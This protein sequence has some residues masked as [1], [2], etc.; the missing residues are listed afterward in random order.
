MIFTLL[1]CVNPWAH[2]RHP[3]W[4]VSSRLPHQIASIARDLS[5]QEAEF[6]MIVESNDGVPAVLTNFRGCRKSTVCKRYA[7]RTPG[8]S[9]ASASTFRDDP[10]KNLTSFH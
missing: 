8:S 7:A 6:A 1:W 2:S 4:V 5:E 10:E 3:S 9:A